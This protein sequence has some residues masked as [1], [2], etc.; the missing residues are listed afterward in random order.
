MATQLVRKN[1]TTGEYEN[2]YPLV[3]WSQIQNLTTGQTLDEALEQFNHLYIDF[4]NNS[5][6]ETR[7]KVPTNYRRQGLYITYVSC[8]GE[9]VTEYYTGTSFDDESWQDDNNWTQVATV[10]NIEEYIADNIKWYYYKTPEEGRTKKSTYIDRWFLFY[11]TKAAYDLQLANDLIDPESI[12]FIEDTGQIATQGLLFGIDETCIELLQTK[13][14]ALENIIKGDDSS[15]AIDSLQK[16]INFFANYTTEDTLSSVLNTLETTITNAYTEK[17]NEVQSNVDEIQ[18]EVN[19]LSSK[20]NQYY[21]ELK[22]ADSLLEA[23]IL[24]NT[25]SIEDLQSTTEDLQ[26]QITENTKNISSIRQSISL[27]NTQITEMST[28]FGTA[29]DKLKARVSTLET[30]TDTLN[31]SI[32]AINNKIDNLSSDDISNASEVEGST[33]TDALNN[34]NDVVSGL[35]SV[36]TYKGSVDTYNDLPTEAEVGDVYNVIA[37]YGDYPAGTNWAW[38]GSEWDPLGGSIDLSKYVTQE[39]LDEKLKDI[40]VDLNYATDAEVT[41][42]VDSLFSKGNNN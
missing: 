13:V 26:T 18:T 17:I 32:N 30:I 28:S 4:T 22:A 11:E 40:D 39:E 25:S 14:E 41:S 5:R 7:L 38:T 10:D 16:V 42:D 37:A 15:T 1:C 27:I 23:K 8:D 12:C 33:V 2:I 20:V 9:V 29:L 19:S 34:L 36:M 24:F 35:T 21:T 3:D 31:N 6:Y